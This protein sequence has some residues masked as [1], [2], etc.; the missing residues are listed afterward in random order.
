[1]RFAGD[2]NRGPTTVSPHR[3]CPGET[4][5]SMLQ[6]PTLT[7]EMAEATLPPHK[8]ARYD[9]P[10]GPL[11]WPYGESA[12]WGG[13]FLSDAPHMYGM[14]AQQYPGVPF[15]ADPRMPLRRSSSPDSVPPVQHY[16]PPQVRSGRGAMRLASNRGTTSP[17]TTPVVRQGI[18]VSNRGKGP[19]KPA[20]CRNNLATSPAT[21]AP[22]REGA[23][24]PATSTTTEGQPTTAAAAA[25]LSSEAQRIGSSVQA[26]AVAI[27]RKTKRKLPMAA[28][29]AEECSVA[30]ATTE[31]KANAAPAATTPASTPDDETKS[32][33][34][35]EETKPAE[36][37]S[38]EA[39]PAST[40][41]KN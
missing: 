14:R 25:D 1:M 22:K 7:R 38:V 20:A 3:P 37:T 28:K 40:D 33:T 19:R 41:E 27:S 16:S 23:T 32:S 13:Q 8:R 36:S 10:G 12:V 34:A 21:V 6:V 35:E 11:H 39:A 2:D 5:R 26:V 4:E 15:G 31:A 29:K 30:E 17:S 9:G 18:S 24:S